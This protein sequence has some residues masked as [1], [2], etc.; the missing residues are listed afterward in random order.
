MVVGVDA[1]NARD[2]GK[3]DEECEAIGGRKPIAVAL[4]A[5]GA[6]I[7][8]RESLYVAGDFIEQLPAP[9]SVVPSPAPLELQGTVTLAARGK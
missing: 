5:S 9:H 7:E 2:G 8:K 3:L 1:L 4:R 6:R